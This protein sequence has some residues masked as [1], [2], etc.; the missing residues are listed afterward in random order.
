MTE[1]DK[2]GDAEAAPQRRRHIGVIAAVLV[3]VLGFTM[4]VQIRSHSD[5]SL[6]SARTEDLVRILS[7]LDSQRGRLSDEIDQLN[8][9]RDDLANGSKRHDAALKRAKELAD[10]VEILAGTAT[11]TGKGLTVTLTPGGAPIRAATM[12]D[13]VEELR[14]AGAEVMQI[15]GD[16]GTSVRIVASSS[17]ASDGDDLAVDNVTLAAPYR[18]RVIGDPDTMATAIDIPGGVADTVKKDG[19]NVVVAKPG[20]VKVTT[21]AK[22]KPPKYAVP[23]D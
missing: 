4:V 7:D 13:A 20:T 2:A 16:A 3:A 11:A 12:L 17:F 23:V 15:D 22:V 1:D 9:D 5:D 19:G 6:A 18:I 8:T 10:S 21:L 14:G